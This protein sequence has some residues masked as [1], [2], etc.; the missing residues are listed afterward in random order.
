MSCKEI[1]KQCYSLRR[2]VLSCSVYNCTSVFIKG[3][4]NP[5][6]FHKFPKDVELCKK[7]IF[8]SGRP[9][10]LKKSHSNILNYRLCSLHFETYS[11]KTIKCVHL[12]S[13]AIPINCNLS[14][15]SATL[16]EEICDG[17]L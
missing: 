8:A 6:I 4:N 10:F 13:D 3:V 1:K 15:T 5:L 11:Y 9:E 12:K 16:N 7:W 2:A 14:S 17:K